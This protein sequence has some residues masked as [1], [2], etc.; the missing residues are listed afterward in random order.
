M[1]PPPPQTG[2]PQTYGA[3]TGPRAGFWQR[4]AAV[5]IDGIIIGI[6]PLIL[7]I[8]AAGSHNRGLVVAAYL[9]GIAGGVA[10]EVY[11]IGG[12]TGQTVGKRAM[13]IRVIDY[14]TGGPLG[15]GRAFLRLIG[16][17]V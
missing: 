1:Y 14:N 9:I 16:R 12:P 2:Q 13:G 15:Y 4:F 8:A 17:Y 5:F 10:Y 11:F 6:V 7:V 3:S